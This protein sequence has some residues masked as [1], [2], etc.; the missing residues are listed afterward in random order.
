[1]QCNKCGKELSLEDKVCTVCGNVLVEDTP[2]LDHKVEVSKESVEEFSV[3]LTSETEVE[4]EVPRPVFEENTTK[5]EVKEEVVIETPKEE[6]VTTSTL[7]PPPTKEEIEVKEEEK[8]NT[9]DFLNHSSVPETTPTSV[10]MPQPTPEVQSVQPV[11]EETTSNASFA[12]EPVTNNFD[13]T[14]NTVQVDYNRV[15]MNNAPIAPVASVNKRF[16]PVLIVVAIVLCVLFLGGGILVGTLLF[17]NKTDT[18]TVPEEKVEKVKTTSV[19]FAGNKFEI[20]IDYDYEVK[21]GK[22]SI[23][24]DS[25]YF[26]VQVAPSSYAQ[27]AANIPYIK[28]NYAKLGYTV[29]NAEEKSVLNSKYVVL[30]LIKSTGEKVT[31]FLRAFTTN[32]SFVCAVG[33]SDGNFATLNE[34]STIENILA[35]KTLMATKS[36]DQ[37]DDVKDDDLLGVIVKGTLPSANTQDEDN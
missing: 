18:P 1:M 23:Y 6:V 10:E 12:S 2:D 20:P 27:Y 25:I 22:L 7:T 14:P 17:G 3:P 34:L 4:N 8:V 13:Y 5:E 19:I 33:R 9:F 26:Y 11:K 31:L 28:N 30:D 15:N 29:E 35:T 16:S 37:E 32:Q 21:E 36:F 24:D